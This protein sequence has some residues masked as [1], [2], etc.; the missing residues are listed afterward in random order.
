MLLCADLRAELPKMQE[1]NQKVAFRVAF[2]R[3]LLDEGTMRL[4]MLLV[5]A[6]ALAFPRPCFKQ[7]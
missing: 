4:C 6:L 1:V 3:L 7:P 2:Q 5:I